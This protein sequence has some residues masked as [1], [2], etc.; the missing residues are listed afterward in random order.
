M[1]VVWPQLNWLNLRV[2]NLSRYVIMIRLT[3]R[4]F[5]VSN[6]LRGGGRTRHRANRLVIANMATSCFS[7]SLVIL[8]AN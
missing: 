8:L 3:A 1:P 7:F 4:L 2:R 6:S 5:L